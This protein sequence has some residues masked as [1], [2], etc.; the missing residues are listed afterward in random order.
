MIKLEY[1]NT[2]PY[3]YH[4]DRRGAKYKIGGKFKNSGELCESIAKHHRGLD[5]LVNPSTSYDEGSD[6]E[7]EGASVKSSGATLACLYGETLDEIIETYFAKTASTKWIYVV[8][9]DEIITEYHMNAKEF[10][11]FIK[12]FCRL[13]RESGKIEKKVRFRDT[14]AKT[15]AWLEERVA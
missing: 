15:I 2:M 3:E 14:S 6:I 7:S 8:R 12:A 1:I 4:P 10:G 9:V 13:D 11:E 5:Y